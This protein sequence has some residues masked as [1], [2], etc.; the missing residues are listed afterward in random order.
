MGKQIQAKTIKETIATTLA[1]VC[2]PIADELGEEFAERVG[3]WRQKNSLKVLE[4]TNNKISKLALSNDKRAHPRLVHK[5]VEDGSW[6]DDDRVQD[7]WAGLLVSSCTESGKDES[8]L[9]FINI[10]SQLTSVQVQ[11]L[12]YACEKAEK[13]IT[14]AGW[15]TAQIVTATLEELK[16]ITGEEDFHRLDRDMDNMRAHELIQ[17]GFPESS[18]T[19]NITPSGFGLQLYVRAQ[20]YVGSPIE[21]FGL[22]AR[23]ETT[24]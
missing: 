22:N 6:S 13:E 19:A 18:T 12:N 5:I 21:Y 10:L 23:D 11:I 17:G 14:S 4:K 8:N 20:G 3:S 7:M 9:I 15:I 1:K 2:Y 24:S 16:N